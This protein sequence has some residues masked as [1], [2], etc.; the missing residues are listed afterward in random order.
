MYPSR[1]LQHI[2]LI[3]DEMLPTVAPSAWSHNAVPVNTPEPGFP[4]PRVHRAGLLLTP[5]KLVTRIEAGE[6]IDMAELLSEKLD[7][8]RILSTD[9][10]EPLRKAGPPKDF[11]YR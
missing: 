11:I 6:F 9:E 10:R 4:T 7:P 5:A 8:P 3:G 2:L 1:M